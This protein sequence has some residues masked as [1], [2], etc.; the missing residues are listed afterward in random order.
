MTGLRAA[1]LPAD[2]RLA[3]AGR[4]LESAMTFSDRP[5]GTAFWYE[6][7]NGLAE[8]AVKRGAR[9]HSVWRSGAPSRSSLE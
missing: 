7:S 3:A 1:L 5:P 6:N 9:M 2:A 8:I 4:V